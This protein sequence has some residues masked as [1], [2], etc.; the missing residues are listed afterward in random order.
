M[1]G[2]KKG[3][4]SYIQTFWLILLP[5]APTITEESATQDGHISSETG[6]LIQSKLFHSGAVFHH[7]PFL[8]YF[9]TETQSKFHSY[10]IHRVRLN[11]SSS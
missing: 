4:N 1:E 7:A 2:N 10:P 8:W 5:T 3:I 9:F 11:I 6:T